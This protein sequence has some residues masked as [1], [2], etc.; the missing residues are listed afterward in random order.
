MTEPL[1]SEADIRELTAEFESAYKDSTPAEREASKLFAIARIA[2][3]SA[4]AH[5]LTL[6]DHLARRLDVAET[7]IRARDDQLQRHRDHLRRLQDKMAVLE[8][9]VKGEKR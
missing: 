1:F 3:K 6:N 5:A 4:R 2:V 9:L 7:Q 8:L